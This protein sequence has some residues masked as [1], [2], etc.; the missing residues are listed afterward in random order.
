[1][2]WSVDSR[3][4]I[5][6]FPVLSRQRLGKKAVGAIHCRTTSPLRCDVPPMEQVGAHEVALPGTVGYLSISV[7]ASR[8]RLTA[9]AE[10]SAVTFGQ[11]GVFC[12]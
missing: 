12:I 5:P 1:M 8:F 6:L 9:V 7:L 11:A 4:W 3:G 2:A 10:I